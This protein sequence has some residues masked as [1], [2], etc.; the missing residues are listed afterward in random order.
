[1]C[2]D[3]PPY[4]AEAA[5]CRLGIMTMRPGITEYGLR[6][7]LLATADI[8]CPGRVRRLGSA[9][10]GPRATGFAGTFNTWRANA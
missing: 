5:M 1:M 4:V 7:C 6:R 10:D 3:H 2:E 8:N 9:G